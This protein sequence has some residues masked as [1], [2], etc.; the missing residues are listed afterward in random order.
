VRTKKWGCVS[1]DLIIAVSETAS[2]NT[3]IVVFVD[4]LTKM[5]HLAACKTTIETQAFAKMLRHEV[6]RS[7][8]VPYEFVTESRHESSMPHG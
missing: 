6:T 8:E 2:D 3:P 4:R 7:H 5:V 1:R